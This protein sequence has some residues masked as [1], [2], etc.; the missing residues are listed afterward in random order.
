M[1]E[2]RADADSV[3]QQANNRYNMHLAL[4]VCQVDTTCLTDNLATQV[5]RV[6]FFILSPSNTN[7]SF[8][9]QI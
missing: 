7:L 8:L 2:T 4:D 9:T 1:S 6:L 5:R 3:T